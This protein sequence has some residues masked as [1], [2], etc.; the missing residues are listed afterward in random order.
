MLSIAALLAKK[1]KAKGSKR[2][3]ELTWRF[4]LAGAWVPSR[5]V[6]ATEKNGG[7]KGVTE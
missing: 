7:V 2:V 1:G 4:G 6:S 5:R 3:A